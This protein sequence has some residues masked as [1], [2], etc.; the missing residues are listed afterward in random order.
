MKSF[1][2]R[3]DTLDAPLYVCCVIFNATRFRTRWK[4]YGDFEREIADRGG[5][6]YTAEVAFGDR[7]FTV[8]EPD[9]P[10]HLQLR[11]RPHELWVKEN[12]LNL[13]V[14]R[15]PRDFQKVAFCDT[16]ISWARGDI[17]DETKHALE[18]Y[19]VVQMWSEAEDLSPDYEVIQNHH[20]FVYSWKHD[21][22][23]PDDEGYYLPPGPGEGRV[24]HW[25]PGF[26][27]AWRRQAF[28]DVEGLMD[29]AILGAGD[30][31]M[32]HALIGAGDHTVH[33]E[34]Q[35]SY[36]RWV[37]IW[38]HRAKA[39]KRNVGYVPGLL[40]HY[41]HG[42]K[43][44]RGYWSRWRILVD[45]K[46]EPETDLKRDWQGLWD[47]VVESDRQQELRDAVRAYFRARNEDGTDLE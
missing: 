17:I 21:E 20:S 3:P 47:L 6:L 8:T 28:S 43:V 9:N 1:F 5:I 13:L 34:I 15:L 31:H 33:G 38:E 30:N 25:H 23:E 12:V 16:D 37:A 14:Q 36:R 40:L 19:D 39:I 22:P 41:W 35:G 46:F 24:I 7:E 42:Q 2:K 29:W 26:A 27:W 32:A 10:R 44:S 4:L 11:T 18:H 45:S